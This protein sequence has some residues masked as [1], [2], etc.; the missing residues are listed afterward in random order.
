M[1]TAALISLA[2]AIGCTATGRAFGNPAKHYLEEIRIDG[3]TVVDQM[4]DSSEVGAWADAL[5]IGPPMTDVRGIVTAPGLELGPAPEV[6]RSDESIVGPDGATWEAYGKGANGCR[7]SI[8]Q[9]IDDAYDASRLSPSEITSVHNGAAA[10]LRV[11][12]TCGDG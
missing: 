12:V 4:S 1:V 9:G 2:T 3:Y 10:I 11:H 5:F 8:H 7:V 6:A